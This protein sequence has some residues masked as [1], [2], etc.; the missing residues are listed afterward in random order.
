MLGVWV[1]MLIKTGQEQ[2]Y[3]LPIVGELAERSVSEQK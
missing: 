1:F 3:S 2:F